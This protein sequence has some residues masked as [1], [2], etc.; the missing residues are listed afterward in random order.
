[1]LPVNVLEQASELLESAKTQ[2]RLASCSHSFSYRSSLNVGRSQ[3]GAVRT[4]SVFRITLITA[5]GWTIPEVTLAFELAII[6][7]SC[8]ISAKLVPLRL[9]D[10]RGAPEE[11]V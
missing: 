6:V 4:W 11:V 8:A 10:R 2:T 7:F 5:Y 1:M 9:G 3:L